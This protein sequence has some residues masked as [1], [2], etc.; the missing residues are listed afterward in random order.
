MAAAG[1]SGNYHAIL[2]GEPPTFTSAELSDAAA[3]SGR[4]WRHEN[5]TG[6][7]DENWADWYAEYIVRE[8]AGSPLPS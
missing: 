7:H 4:A 6:G 8:Q 3:R 2:A 1:C 5:R